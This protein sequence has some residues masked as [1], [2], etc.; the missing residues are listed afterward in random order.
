M[1][2]INFTVLSPNG[3]ITALVTTKVDK[4]LYKIIN[5]AIMSSNKDIEQVGFIE[6]KED[7]IFLEMAGGEFCVNASRCAAFYFNNKES[8]SGIINVSGIPLPVNYAVKIEKT[9]NFVSIELP[10][11]KNAIEKVEDGVLVKLDGITHLVVYSDSFDE[12]MLSELDENA[13]KLFSKYNLYNLGASG[14]TYFNRKSNQAN[15]FV[16]VKAIK[17]YFRETACGSGTCAIGLS[18]FKYQNFNKLEVK[19]P[20]NELMIVDIVEGKDNFSAK[21]SGNIELVEENSTIIFD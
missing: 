12:K 18:L 9:S 13:K 3:N 4:S 7:Q 20:S 8:S 6:K 5:D 10:V 15:F 17:T 14:I 21:I 1:M 16:W 19:Q 2:Q 11:S